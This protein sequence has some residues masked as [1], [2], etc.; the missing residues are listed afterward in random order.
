MRTLFTTYPYILI[1]L[2]TNREQVCWRDISFKIQIYIPFFCFGF[3]PSFVKNL[4][5]GR[6]SNFFNLYN[7]LVRVK[8]SNHVFI[9]RLTHH[10]YVR[11]DK[12]QKSIQIY[13]S[14][15]PFNF[16]YGHIQRNIFLSWYAN[17]IL[18]FLTSNF[19]ICCVNIC[20]KVDLF[21]GFYLMYIVFTPNPLSV[22]FRK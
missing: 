1:S 4:F 21:S 6:Y 5:C 12:Y 7:I 2:A 3:Q 14:C 16:L 17:Y 15:S 11:V 22:N 8:L 10:K 19:E 9:T 13:L 20:E 18:L